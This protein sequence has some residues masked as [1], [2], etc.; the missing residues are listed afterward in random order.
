MKYKIWRLLLI[1]TV[2]L[3]IA[4]CSD[5][6]RSDGDPEFSEAKDRDIQS[7]NIRKAGEAS[8]NRFPCD[9]VALR[10]Y[11]LN[12]YPAG[13]YLVE[14]DKN[15]TYNVGKPAVIYYNADRK[16]VFA[17]IAKS[18]AGERLIEPKNIIGFESSFVNL[19]STKLGTAFFF[20]TLFACNDDQFEF[21]WEHEIP[22]HGGFNNMTVKTWRP[23]NVLYVDVNYEDGIIVG[24]RNY[25]FFMLNGLT[26]FPHMLETYVGLSCKRTMANINN[27]IYP[28]Y[29]EYIY[30]DVGK[31]IYSPDS[32]AFLWKEKQNLY[33][34]TRNPRQ[35]RPY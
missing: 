20:L 11:I 14:F 33:V 18:K 31:R 10:E 29:Y 3:I 1:L 4:S 16:Y 7:Y 2:P 27:D 35:T 8:E 9:T 30:Y 6:K 15:A 25:N 12:N 28:D 23:K 26:S 32:V 34:N 21:I 5:D 17:I 22:V 19:D 24:N 13:S